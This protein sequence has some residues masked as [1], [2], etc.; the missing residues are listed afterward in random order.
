[1]QLVSG[2]K[3][4]LNQVI[5][6][7]QKF[8]LT[9]Q[10]K[11]AFEIDISSFGVGQNDQLFHDDYMTFYNQSQTPHCE[12]Q[13][14]QQENLDLLTFDLSKINATQT[15]RF[16]ICATVANDQATMQN[17]QSGQISLV[18][19]QGEVLANYQLNPSNFSQ[20]KAVMLTEIYFKNDLWRM[21]AIGQGFNGGLTALVRHFGGEVAENSSP[22]PT[23]SKIDL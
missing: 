17:I 20:E 10:F 16:V 2:Q 9:V 5:Q 14:R 18:N 3:I 12:V 13:Y 21:A 8:T 7:D 19:Q 11:A 6:N 1:M 15:P 23:K 4:A 22:A